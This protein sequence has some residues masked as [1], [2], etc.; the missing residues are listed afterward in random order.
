MNNHRLVQID[1]NILV[2]NVIFGIIHGISHITEGKIMWTA[3]DI[4]FPILTQVQ[5]PLIAIIFLMKNIETNKLLFNVTLTI[6]FLL[7]FVYGGFNLYRH[8]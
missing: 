7:I 2:V 3:F 8:L 5:I 1:Y 4:L 6:D